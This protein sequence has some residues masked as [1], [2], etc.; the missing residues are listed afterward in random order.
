M[1][2]KTPL[3]KSY[4]AALAILL[5]LSLEGHKDAIAH[6]PSNPHDGL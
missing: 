3:Q 1:S 6:D 2:C 4:N 5:G